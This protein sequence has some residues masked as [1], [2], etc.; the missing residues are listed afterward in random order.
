MTSYAPWQTALSSAA[1]TP[2]RWVAVGDSITEGQGAT[3]RANR[4]VQKALGLFR[5]AAGVGGGGVGF[6]PPAY[7]TYNDGAGS[8]WGSAG[9][10][11][12]GTIA[13][14]QFIGLGYRARQLDASGTVTWAVTGTGVDIWYAS[15]SG[16]GSFTWAID[17]GTTTAVNTNGT[18]SQMKV[19]VTFG[20]TGSHTVTVTR[21]AGTVYIGGITVYD[22]DATG[23]VTVYDAGHT[24][25]DSTQ[26]VGLSTISSGTTPDYATQL[27]TWQAIG[28]K[29]LTVELGLN[30]YLNNTAT[31]AQ[32]Q[33]HVRQIVTDTKAMGAT[34]LIIIAYTPTPGLA[35]VGQTLAWSDYAS[36]L[37]TIATTD[38]SVGLLDLTATMPQATTSGTGFYQP[39]G[40]HP[41]DVGHAEVARQLATMLSGGTR[42]GFGI[43][44]IG[45]LSL[46][47]ALTTF[48]D[49]VNQ[50]TKVRSSAITG[51]ES[52]PP[53]PLPF[54]QQVQDDIPGL[55]GA[56][57]PVSFT[58][59]TDRNGYY[60]VVDVGAQMTNMTGELV[61]VAWSFTLNRL[62]SD[63]EV[64][65]ESRLTGASARNNSFAATGE[66]THAPPV[67][68][69]AY[70]SGPTQPSVVTRA[71]ADGSMLV[72][73]G[74]PATANARWG[75]AVANYSLGRC[76]FVDANGLERAGLNFRTPDSSWS[77][78]NGLIQ[79]RPGAGALS[80]GAWTSGAYAAKTWDIL[81]NGASLGL[82]TATVVLRNEYETTVVRLLWTQ[83]SPGR[84]TADLTIRRGSRLVEMYI[85][86][87][88][89]STIK[90]VRQVTEAATAGTGYVRA[91]A[92]DGSGNRFVLGSAK[93]F[94]NDL[95]L[96]GISVASSVTLDAFIGVE[97]AGSAAV[98]GDQAAQLYA[99]YLGMPSESIQVA[100]R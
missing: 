57:L 51:E 18:Y 98:S 53:S 9:I 89:S 90:V 37:R 43:A 32:L 83:A 48:D 81:I 10:T 41:N 60:E 58:N 45:R 88:F 66:R 28:P 46:R 84:V 31:P 1:S 7:A 44:Q 97:L 26:Y 72:Y 67:G 8:N 82:P 40:L 80:V 35:V 75:C 65:L 52:F 50:N 13:Q 20:T 16:G 63:T 64:D 36:A 38:P 47:E 11:S 3:T 14:A 30:D 74:L 95:T 55:M 70:W 79:V 21:T 68:H 23:G 78:S 27:A 25:I 24:G 69:Y 85:Q 71:T 39:D 33:T 61:K 59:K 76:R 86:P 42:T 49:K 99:A 91:T 29:L 2:A 56:V 87:E 73:R 94:T 100:R 5:A 17:G 12:A 19:P 93:T 34:P 92:N 54:I 77:I 96:G 15:F 6:V 62:G 22:G 4:Y